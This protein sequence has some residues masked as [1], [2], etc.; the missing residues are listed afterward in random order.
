MQRRSIGG[1]CGGSMV[2]PAL[3]ASFWTISVVQ[4]GEGGGRWLSCIFGLVF[5][6]GWCG[7]RLEFP[8][9]LRS[10]GGKWAA[11]SFS[12]GF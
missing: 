11:S 12:G 5:C 3:E 2:V 8:A 1:V 10:N 6:G 4:N 7:W 9:D